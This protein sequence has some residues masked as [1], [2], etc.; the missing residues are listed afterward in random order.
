MKGRQIDDDLPFTSSLCRM[1]TRTRAEL[2]LRQ[3]PQT[4]S[5][6]FPWEAAGTH[7]PS[8]LV[9]VTIHF[10]RKLESGTEPGL[11]PRHLAMSRMLHPMHLFR[12]PVTQDKK[13]GNLF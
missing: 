6:S 2:E 11:E 12:T 10:V 8:S 1:L 3:K 13:P 4:Q 5:T 7:G 9:P